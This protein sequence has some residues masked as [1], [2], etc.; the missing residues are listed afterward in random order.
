MKDFIVTK[1]VDKIKFEG[2]WGEL[3]SKKGFQRQAFTKYLRFLFSC[4]IAHYGKGLISVSEEVFASIDKTFILAG[5]LGTGLFFLE[6]G[7]YLDISYFPKFVLSR[8]ATREVT[9][10]YHVC[11]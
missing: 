10:I 9:R 3:K 2:V 7:P 6:F 5:R 4:E 8:S 1:I 11:K